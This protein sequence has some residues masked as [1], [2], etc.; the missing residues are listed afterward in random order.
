VQFWQPSDILRLIALVG[1]FLLCGLGAYLMWL[2][3]GAEGS[4]DIKSSILSGS[5]KTGSAGLFLIFFGGAIVMFVLAT[6][7]ASAGAK[8]ATPVV[9]KT[10]A[11]S[12]GV[13]F[14]V[15]L[16]A[17]VLAAALG[18]FGYGDGFGILAIFLG[19]FLLLTAA[20]YAEFASRD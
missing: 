5:V 16:T 17:L 6:L 19:L 4:V 7:G 3:V 11:H 13:A 2:G 8:S 20:A 14:F 9:R 15:V 1:G 12:I 10:T 18:A